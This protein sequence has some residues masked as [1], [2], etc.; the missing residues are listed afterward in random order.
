MQHPDTE[1]VETDENQACE[2]Q[3]TLQGNNM[4]SL[5][6]RENKTVDDKKQED[7]AEVLKNNEDVLPAE[8]ENVEGKANPE[9]EDGLVAKEDPSLTEK[10]GN[11][12]ENVIT[13]NQDSVDQL[14]DGSK[15]MVKNESE[16][17]TDQNENESTDRGDLEEQDPNFEEKC[18]LV[19]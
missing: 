16:E 10:E 15:E 19:L 11:A 3:A 1:K 6:I 12:E 18:R 5:D 14:E 4:E 8:V 7:P 9:H 13:K 17:K 2:D